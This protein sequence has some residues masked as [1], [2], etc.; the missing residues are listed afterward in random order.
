MTHG[1][2]PYS[3]TL[4]S[5]NRPSSGSFINAEEP[6]LGFY[7]NGEIDSGS[8]IQTQSYGNGMKQ[9]IGIVVVDLVSQTAR[10]L[11]T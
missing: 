10:N 2:N 9:L 8:E 6:G 1:W 4:G 11:S 5:A 3:S 7:F